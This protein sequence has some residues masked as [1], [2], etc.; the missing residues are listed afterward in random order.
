MST[1]S[2]S[3]GLSSFPTCLSKKRFSVWDYRFVD[4]LSNTL[5][6]LLKWVPLSCPAGL[7]SVVSVVSD[8]ARNPL[9]AARLTDSAPRLSCLPPYKYIACLHTNISSLPSKSC[10]PRVLHRMSENPRT[11]PPFPMLDT[12]PKLSYSFLQLPHSHSD[13]LFHTLFTQME[14]NGF[15][16]H[17]IVLN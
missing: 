5:Q 13:F 1:V 16:K 8:I 2:H 10:Y 11:C 4:Y 9:A 6:F 12:P 7:A 15:S 3:L 14:P 17:W